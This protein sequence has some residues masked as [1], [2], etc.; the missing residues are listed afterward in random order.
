MTQ[1]QLHLKRVQNCGWW[2][3]KAFLF[4][5]IFNLVSNVSRTIFQTTVFLNNLKDKRC[6]GEVKR[7]HRGHRSE[8]E[9]K[10]VPPDSTEG[11]QA[12]RKSLIFG[13]VYT[14]MEKGWNNLMADGYS[15]MRLGRNCCYQ[16]P[17]NVHTVCWEE[18]EADR[19]TCPGSMVLHTWNGFTQTA[20]GSTQTLCP[21]R[22]HSLWPPFTV[23]MQPVIYKLSR[24][25]FCLS[26]DSV[27]YYQFAKYKNP[28]CLHVWGQCVKVNRRIV[29][30]LIWWSHRDRSRS[31]LLS[32][33]GTAV[34]SGFFPGTI[35]LTTKPAF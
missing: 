10:C 26:A 33:A 12:V 16:K 15:S 19:Q 21:H 14:G 3:Q 7:R 27:N 30:A 17:I 24:D 32:T 35:T 34:R 20:W 28:L 11:Q 4:L 13:I 23:S 31:T 2:L 25:G 5:F 9:R 8:A 6:H 22:R 1:Q 29:S 18:H